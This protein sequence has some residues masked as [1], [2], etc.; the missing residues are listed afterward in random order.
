MDW[1]CHIW[2]QIFFQNFGW[3]ILSVKLLNCNL[4]GVWKV[5]FDSCFF[6]FLNFS[7]LRLEVI[8]WTFGLF[9]ANMHG[10][11]FIRP[12]LN[13]S[14]HKSVKFDNCIKLTL[15]INFRR[16]SC[17]MMISLFLNYP[18]VWF[19]NELKLPLYFRTKD[20]P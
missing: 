3:R 1:I 8:M 7:A 20:Y 4:Y 17:H 6:T 15:T 11:L 19:G 14:L 5:L 16:I 10:Y 2:Q 13:I 9:E 18:W 12:S